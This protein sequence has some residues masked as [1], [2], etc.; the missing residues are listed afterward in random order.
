MRSPH[1]TTSALSFCSMCVWVLQNSASRVTVRCHCKCR[2]LL[3]ARA[4]QP[5]TTQPSKTCLTTTTVSS[6]RSRSPADHNQQ[7]RAPSV[8]PSRCRVRRALDARR[9]ADVHSM[10]L[11]FCGGPEAH[12]TGTGV[13]RFP[14]APPPNISAEELARALAPPD[15]IMAGRHPHRSCLGLVGAFASTSHSILRIR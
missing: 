7:F 1:R 4:P 15:P 8:R 14:P 13:R 10:A 3:W 2:V 5:A 11:R 9:N 6:K 12:R